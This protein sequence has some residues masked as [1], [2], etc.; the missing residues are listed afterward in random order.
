[1]G[2]S[3]VGS[4]FDEG[5][6]MQ[7]L[8]EVILREPVAWLYEPELWTAFA[9]ALGFTQVRRDVDEPLTAV[10]IHICN[11]STGLASPHDR[12]TDVYH[13]ITSHGASLEGGRGIAVNPC[14]RRVT[15]IYNP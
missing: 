3:N 11:G 5:S 9:Y 12:V 10:F 4:S 14:H 8:L 15:T 7:T 6:G 1:M 2:R 13:I